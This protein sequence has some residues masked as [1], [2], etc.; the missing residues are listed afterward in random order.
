VIVWAHRTEND[1]EV[2]QA[3]IPKE[4]KSVMRVEKPQKGKCDLIG[5]VK[6]LNWRLNY[7]NGLWS[8]ICEDCYEMLKRFS[9]KEEWEIKKF[10]E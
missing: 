9:L 8:G 2:L 4:L 7:V 1:S 10:F 6:L 5:H 3:E